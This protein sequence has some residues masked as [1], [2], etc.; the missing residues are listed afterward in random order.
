MGWANGATSA[1]LPPKLT[2]EQLLSRWDRHTK[3]CASC[4]KV[5]NIFSQICSTP[6]TVLNWLYMFSTKVAIVH[7]LHKAGG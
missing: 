2:R 5:R 3:D 7:M 4:K 6:V 1:D